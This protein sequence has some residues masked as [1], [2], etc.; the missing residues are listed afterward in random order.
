MAKDGI[1]TICGGQLYQPI[2]LQSE[3]FILFGQ[4]I[5]QKCRTIDVKLPFAKK[6][7]V[8]HD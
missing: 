2:V 4:R 7:E 1:C 8:C 5:C 3:Y 6:S